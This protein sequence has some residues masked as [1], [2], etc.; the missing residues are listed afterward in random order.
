MSKHDPLVSI[1]DIKH[2]LDL[3]QDFITE[4]LVRNHYRN[5]LQQALL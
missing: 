4:A 5:T 2:N 1:A 3:I